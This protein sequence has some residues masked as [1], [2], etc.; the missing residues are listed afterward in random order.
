MNK[1]SY[2]QLT[3][4]YIVLSVV[5]ASPLLNGG[6]SKVVLLGTGLKGYHKVNS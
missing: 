1:V 3:K 2:V 5:Q 4:Y 6:P